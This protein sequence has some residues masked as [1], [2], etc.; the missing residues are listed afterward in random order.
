MNASTKW[1]TGIPNA[2]ETE[3]LRGRVELYWICDWVSAKKK[4]EAGW[5]KMSGR[6]TDQ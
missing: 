6:A 5:E 3:W 4:T 1:Y 2:S